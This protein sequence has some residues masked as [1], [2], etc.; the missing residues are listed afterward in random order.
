MLVLAIDFSV[1]D[2]HMKRQPRRSNFLH[3]Y[4]PLE[5]KRLLA[6]N[7]EAF[8]DGTTLQINGDNLANQIQLT[9]TSD[10]ATVVSGIDTTINGQ[11]TAF[12][13]AANVTRLRMNLEAGDDQVDIEN[14]SISRDMFIFG[15][16]GNDRLTL[17]NVQGRF[18]HLQGNNGDD[19][20][21][22]NGVIDR[23]SAY[24]F[25]GDGN[26]VL[27]VSSLQTRRN[28]KVF[29]GS[30]DDTFVSAE[31]SVGRKFRL[32]LDNGNDQALLAG[33]TTVRKNS[34]IRLGNGDDFLGVLPQQTDE[35]S[36]F[37]RRVKISAGGGNDTVAFDEGVTSRRPSRFV[38][39]SGTDSIDTGDANLHRHTR[40]RRFES[41]SIPTAELTGRIDDVFARLEAVG[42]DTE[43]F[44]DTAD[45]A[46]SDLELTFDSAPL[47]FTENDSPLSIDSSLTIAGPFPNP[48]SLQQLRLWATLVTRT[49]CYSTIPTPLQETLTHPRER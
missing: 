15:G 43:L 12:S 21:Q 24:V 17:T 2:T 14:Y 36:V 32:N 11:A 20:I 34:R 13:T 38:G 26:D 7:V 35:T 25:L 40:I 23:G 33:N 48:L 39:G 4:A 5:T 37:R 6:G 47:S 18:I 31:L 1:W 3:A 8:V 28:F 9:Q 29:G 46:T 44:G 16:D 49:H 10:G 30:G 42:I 22:L 27:A 19:V 45:P 41:N